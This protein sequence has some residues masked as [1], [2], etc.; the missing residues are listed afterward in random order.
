MSANIRNLQAKKATTVQAARAI[1]AG[2]GDRDLNAEEQAQYDA[3][4]A[5]I[6]ALGA[7]I[8]REQ[9]LAVE[10]AGMTAGSFVE[11]GHA[12]SMRVNE[13]L[14]A[15][16]KRGFV[17]FGEFFQSAQAAHQ[18][19]QGQRVGRPDQ[20]LQIGAAAPGTV[21][22]EGA[23]GDGGFVIPPQYSTDIW[24]YSLQD[25]SFLPLCDNTTIDSNSMTFPKDETVPWGTDGIRAYW[26]KEALLGTLTK[27][28][29]GLATMRMHKLMALVPLTDELISDTSALNSYLPKRMAR[30]INWKANEAILWGTGDGQPIGAL[31]GGALI[32]VAKEAGQA[33][34][35]L[36]PKNL[37][38]MVSRLPE[39]SYSNAVWVINNDVLPALDNLTLGNYPIYMPV[40][41]G[42]GGARVSPYG[43]LKGLPVYVSQH[44]KTFS[45]QGDVVLMDL[46]YYRTIQKAGGLQSATSMHIYFDADATA[47][48]VS[49]RL[50]GQ[51]AIAAPI[52]PANGSN[53]L[54]PFVQL[55]AR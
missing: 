38:K 52:T 6:Q 37:S 20:R 4:S 15:D 19:S 49:F 33:T 28:K 9:A 46:S 14:E 48:R 12:N 32:T 51:P 23:G 54:S 16:P 1:V 11:V 29:L 8:D 17:N 10:E 5:T 13:N 26:Q 43:L 42:V 22:N 27:P 44:A 34:L 30:S 24:M 18:M 25:T 41:A 53:T 47:F 45:A 3:I 21:G 55:G 35:T 39:G 40:G 36:D 7:R 31:N 50:D 2:A